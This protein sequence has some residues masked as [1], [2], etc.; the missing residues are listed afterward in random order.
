MLVSPSTSM[1]CS[2]RSTLANK[3]WIDIE[4]L[5]REAEAEEDSEDENDE[6]LE[7]SE[8]YS[9]PMRGLV[10]LSDDGDVMIILAEE[11]NRNANEWVAIGEAE[12]NEADLLFDENMVLETEIDDYE[13]V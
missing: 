10:E 5:L 7:D 8:D 11:E 2:A 3:D 4:A 13:Y 9:G 1:Y 12:N 6:D